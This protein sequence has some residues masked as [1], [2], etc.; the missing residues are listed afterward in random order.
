MGPNFKLAFCAVVMVLSC[1]FIWVVISL[2][3]R[4]MSFLHNF[5][6][7]MLQ[8]W[9]SNSK[10][11]SG[12]FAALLQGFVVRTLASQG[13]GRNGNYIDGFANQSILSSALTPNS[14]LSWNQ[15]KFEVSKSYGEMLVLFTL[16]PVTSRRKE[17]QEQKDICDYSVLPFAQV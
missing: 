8:Q 4:K 15:T 3:N 9:V 16:S 12:Y 14:S 13:P 17:K 5:M 11:P 10:I 2:D 6:R 7:A 1:L